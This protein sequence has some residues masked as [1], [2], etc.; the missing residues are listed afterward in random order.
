MPA[1]GAA[2][3][4]PFPWTF[5]NEAATPALTGVEKRRQ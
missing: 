1:T 4:D 5:G 2:E 3:A